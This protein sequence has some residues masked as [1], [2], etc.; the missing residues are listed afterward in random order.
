MVRIFSSLEDLFIL[1]FFYPEFYFI[2][3]AG[4]NIYLASVVHSKFILVF[5]FFLH[6]CTADFTNISGEIHVLF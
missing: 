5:F 2:V 3:N 1:H 4:K 6:S